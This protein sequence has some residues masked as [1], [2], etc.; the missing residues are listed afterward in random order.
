MTACEKQIDIDAGYQEPKLVIDAIGTTDTLLSV[1]ITESR[2]IFGAH[3]SSEGFPPVTNA[4]VNLTANGVIY[5]ASREDNHYLFPYTPQGG[6][7]LSLQIDVPG[8][9]SVSAMTTVPADP[10]IGEV[11]FS[12][13]DDGYDLT[14][15]I[16]LTDR[17]NST[18]YYLITMHHYDT[19]FETYYIQDS[20][21]IHDTIYNHDAYFY[22]DDPLV[23]TDVSVLDMIGEYGIPSFFGETMLFTDERMDGQSHT[24]EIK[25]NNPYYNLPYEVHITF[26]IEVASLSRDAYLYLKTLQSARESSDMLNLFSEPVQIHSNIDGGIGIFAISN[27]RVFT[28]H[29]DNLP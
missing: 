6:D 23:V 22:C 21:P 15:R 29:T 5:T 28:H 14:F 24:I 1:N 9:P 12:D 19:I 2:P 27:R 4:T 13:Y 10:L 8:H 7:Q 25:C 11:A 26:V 17:A 3:S 16:P 18:D 20:V